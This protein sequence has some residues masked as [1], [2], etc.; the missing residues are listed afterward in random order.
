[1]ASNHGSC[2]ESSLYNLYC[3]MGGFPL[4]ENRA[5]NEACSYFNFPGRRRK[6]FIPHGLLCI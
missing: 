4:G 2:H 5:N 1:M 6:Y 3:R